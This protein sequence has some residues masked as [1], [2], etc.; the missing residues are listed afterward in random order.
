MEKRERG[1]RWEV[2][3]GIGA[4]FEEP[5]ASYRSRTSQIFRNRV[6]AAVRI[7]SVWKQSPS[8][9]LFLS[10]HM[11]TRMLYVV[12]GPFSL[13]TRLFS[14]SRSCTDVAIIAKPK[15]SY[16]TIR[17]RLSL[18]RKQNLIRIEH[19]K[20]LTIIPFIEISIA[21][22]INWHMPGVTSE[23]TLSRTRSLQTHVM[24]NVREQEMLFPDLKFPESNRIRE[25]E[26]EREREREREKEGERERENWIDGRIIHTLA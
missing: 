2:P 10:S 18:A 15:S 6:C 12:R 11:C 20:A 16:L 4:V 8:L 25:K 26:R 3:R 14:A 9:S 24:Y 5:R 17:E 21:S 22:S 1:G 23:R 13:F 7:T 19:K